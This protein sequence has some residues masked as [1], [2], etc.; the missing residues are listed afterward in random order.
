[1]ALLYEKVI[2]GVSKVVKNVPRKEV[3]TEVDLSG[4][5]DDPQNQHRPGDRQ[6]HPERVLQSHS[7]G[8]RPGVRG[9]GTSE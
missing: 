6:A 1:L 8:V 2:T 5:L 3:A 9:S 7:P 4:R